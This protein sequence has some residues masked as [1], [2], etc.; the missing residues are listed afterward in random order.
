[1]EEAVGNGKALV[2]A[3]IDEV[4]R[5][6]GIIDRQLLYAK[7]LYADANPAKG[8]DTNSGTKDFPFLTIQAAVN[9]APEYTT[10]VCVDSRVGAAAVGFD[11]NAAIAGVVINTNYITVI[12]CRLF[13][14]RCFGGMVLITNSIANADYVFSGS[15]IGVVVCGFRPILA[16]ANGDEKCIYLTGN[17]ACAIHCD[18]AQSPGSPGFIGIHLTGN[19]AHVRRCHGRWFDNDV[20]RLEGCEMAHVEESILAAGLNGL[21]LLT[22]CLGCVIEHC[23]ILT[24]TVGVLIDAGATNNHICTPHFSNN[25]TDFTNNGGATNDIIDARKESQIV[26]GQ[27]VEQDLKDI[28]DQGA[29]AALCIMQWG[30][31]EDEVLLKSGADPAA[32]DAA[33]KFTPTLPDGATVWK[34]YLVMKFRGIY[35][36]GAN[37]I[38]TAGIVQV[39]KSGGAWVTGITIPIGALDVAAGVSAPGDCLMGNADVSA[40]VASGSEVEFQLVT[41]RSNADDLALRD[42]QFGLQIY[43]TI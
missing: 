1:M 19:D 2:W 10:I 6:R 37:F 5:I 7:V 13:G 20:V 12:G 4:G 32:L 25:T 22:G 28:Y 40:Q 29:H 18:I 24:N 27:A 36:A 26:A 31:F 43:F 3:M 16:N 34:A 38:A 33:T 14:D 8:A 15:G 39:Q 9:A 30:G 23:D 21:H 11:E 35:C 41:L 42:V 17:G